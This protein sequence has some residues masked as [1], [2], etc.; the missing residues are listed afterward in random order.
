[1]Q[2]PSTSFLTAWSRWRRKLWLVGMGLLWLVGGDAVR[3]ELVGEPVTANAPTV[4]S[5]ELSR[6]AEIRLLP[7]EQLQQRRPVQ[8]V[9]VATGVLPELHAFVLQ[10]DTGT[11]YVR[12]ATKT[13]QLPHLAERVEVQ[14]RT[15]VSGVLLGAF[16]RLG[17]GELPAPELASWDQL[18]NSSLEMRLVEVRGVIESLLPR[19]NGW[20]RA[21]LRLREGVLKVELRRA[22]VTPGPLE[23][24]EGAVVRLRGMVF[25]DRYANGRIKVGQIR[26]YDAKVL[27]EQPA[28]TNV[29]AGAPVTIAA[30]TRS[31]PGYNPFLRVKVAGQILFVR[32]YDHFLTDGQDGVRFVTSQVTELEPGDVVEVAGYPEISA[33]APVLRS[34][35]VRKTGHA[36][37]PAPRP[38]S[39]D[40]LI[41]PSFDST[42]V[43]IEGKLASVRDTPTNLVMEIQSGSWR[44][45]ARLKGERASWRTPE[46]GSRLRLTGVYCAQGG[47]SAL[48]EDVAAVDLLLNS[49]AGIVVLATPSWWTPG[50]VLVVAGVLALLLLAALLWVTQLRRRVERRTAELRLQ[51]HERER[52]EHLRVLEQERARIAHDLHDELGADITEVGM[53]AA[54]GAAAAGPVEE[55]RQCLEQLSQK[56]GQMVAALEEIVWAMNPQHDSLGAVASYFSFFADRFLGLANIKLQIESAPEVAGLVVAARVRHQ[57]FLVFKEA[58]TNVVNHAGATEVKVQLRQRDGWLGITVADNGRGL[59]ASPAGNG[60]DGL[61]NMRARMSRLGGRFEILSEAGQGTTLNFSTPLD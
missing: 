36:E 44:F 56:T 32:G 34:A 24:Y 16:Q 50:R 31:N 2:S 57:L 21:N 41:R 20:S 59:P 52:A 10:D 4:A 61:A 8:L 48:G 11:I 38:L 17:A 58:L 60:Q 46:L 43:S 39:P 14:G 51:I 6:V 29:F 53:L 40:D 49:T 22:G 47:Y 13:N 5:V 45:M 28:T 35:L 9:G 25:V 42:L 33:A 55:R 23:R 19:R 37:L 12:D 7:H 3:S 1:M 18:M 54:R 15:D 30:L 27:M 26:M